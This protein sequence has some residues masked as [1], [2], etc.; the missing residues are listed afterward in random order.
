MKI[1]P[2]LFRRRYEQQAKWLRVCPIQEISIFQQKVLNPL[3]I[4][5]SRAVSEKFR[6]LTEHFSANDLL[7][8]VSYFYTQTRNR[9]F[10]FRFLVST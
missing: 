5:R 7:I 3:Q 2:P 4:G 6:K 1:E 9:I 10:C 8:C